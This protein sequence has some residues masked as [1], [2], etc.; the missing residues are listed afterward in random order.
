MKVLR[1]EDTQC[2]PR[3][4]ESVFLWSDRAAAKLT[5]AE[6]PLASQR[7]TPEER[8]CRMAIGEG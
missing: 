5:S 7:T 3:L 2:L 6:Q 4:A 8:F 1:G